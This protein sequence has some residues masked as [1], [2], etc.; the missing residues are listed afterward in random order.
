[1]RDRLRR[2]LGSPTLWASLL[3]V[4]IG[5]GLVRNWSWLR[6]ND[7]FRWMRFD[8][9]G[10][11]SRLWTTAA[12]LGVIGLI[13]V[14]LLGRRWAEARWP[15]RLAGVGALI[16]IGLAARFAF[17]Y[18][19]HPD[20]WVTLFYRTVSTRNLGA[21]YYDAMQI[22]DA[23]AFL[24][25]FP[26][27]MPNFVSLSPQTHP[28]GNL[29]IFWAVG[30]LLERLQ[31]IA[32]AVGPRFRDYLCA[33][34]ESPILFYPD[35]LLAAAGVQ[36][37]I[38]VW[39]ALTVAPFFVMASRLRGVDAAV[40]ASVYLVLTP[41]MVLFLGHWAHAYTLLA[42]AALLFLHLG[43]ERNRL[44]W[45]FLAGLILSIAT[46]MSF[47]N[48]AIGV[49]L[50]GY[51]MAYHLAR[52]RRG[53]ATAP[54]GSYTLAVAPQLLALLAGAVSVWVLY[55]LVFGVSFL[56]VYRQGMATHEAITGYRSYGLWLFANLLDFWLFMGIPALIALIF[57]LR[58][59]IVRPKDPESGLLAYAP[60]W[61]FIFVLLGLDLA[62]ISR[63]EVARLWMPFVPAAWLAVLPVLSRW[64][65]TRL[66]L[67]LVIQLAQLF[68]L[69]AYI[70]T[71]GP[72]NYPTYVPRPVE[73]TAPTDMQVARVAFGDDP[74]IYLLGYHIEERPNEGLQVTLYWQADGRVPFPYTVFIH[75]MNANGELVSQHDS[76]PQNDSAPTMCWR[77]GEVVTDTH[78][79]PASFT[80]LDGGTLAVGMYRLDLVNLEDPNTRLMGRWEGGEGDAYLFPLPSSN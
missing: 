23:Q 26:Q 34:P 61:A 71:V 9:P 52:W 48:L 68:L 33:A 42:M 62:G 36:L 57:T 40:R 32:A 72:S 59:M 44:S 27:E 19:E 24:R 55:R 20:L 6:G 11:E 15:T 63:G 60:L 64:S 18:L 10:L 14:W 80:H 73:L 4:V 41:A 47:T 45:C 3:C 7:E 74:I 8:V 65:R 28:P 76:M 1:M 75:L 43:L 56:E 38:P 39:S 49:F 35:H 67:M 66:S 17:Q 78:T 77:P 29:V 53:D 16:T 58:D 79:L 12:I 46:F 54:W 69:G 37:A 5:I 70:R 2:L 51:L 22:R 30:E 31:W 25:G 21:F 50:I 13:A